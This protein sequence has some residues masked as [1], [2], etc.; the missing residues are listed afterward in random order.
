MLKYN[1]SSSTSTTTTTYKLHYF[2]WAHLTQSEVH[3]PI[4]KICGFNFPFGSGAFVSIG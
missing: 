4:E 3:R 2:D 1:Y